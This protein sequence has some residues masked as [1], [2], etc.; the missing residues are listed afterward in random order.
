MTIQSDG[1]IGI[2]TTSP[3]VGGVM[4]IYSDTQAQARL[5]L[6]GREFY[7]G[8]TS[9]ANGIAMLVGVNR[10]DNKQLWIG[11]SEKLA[12]NTTN[13]V[14]RFN[15]G[16]NGET[17]I[18]SYATNGLTP[19]KLGLNGSIFIKGDGNVGIGVTEPQNKL[20]I[21]SGVVGIP[22]VQFTQTTA[23]DNANYALS[24]SGYTNLGGFRVNGADGG[25]S[26]YQTLANTDMTF[27]QNAG[28]TTAGKII[29]TTFGA[30]GDIVF[31]TSSAERMRIKNNGATTIGNTIN[32]TSAN[33][34]NIGNTSTAPQFPITLSST[35]TQNVSI[36]PSYAIAGTGAYT[37]GSVSTINPAIMLGILG[38]SAFNTGFYIYSDKRI[39]KDVKTIENSL[40][41]IEKINPVSFKYIDYVERGT[42]NN[43]GVIAQEIEKII[44]E[45]INSH[46]DFIP[47]IYKNVDSYDKDLL[48][49]YINTDDLDIGDKIKIFDIKNKE[50]LKTIVDKNDDYITIDEEIKDY[51]DESAIFLYG[52][53]IADVK[54]VNYE[55]LFTIN[56]KATQELYQRLRILEEVVRRLIPI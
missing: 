8:S 53:E 54:N 11:D 5:I 45:V 17:G 18:D 22:L 40:D 9:S 4:T 41:L 48:R 35:L 3:N 1:K 31:N 55:A 44:P 32:I 20:H 38:S 6:T 16:G 56:I 30:N 14:L 23:W 47:N 51:E 43:Y 7:T 50:H 24:V 52:K 10:T 26:I 39:K 29:F 12:V 33:Y 36:S 27:L 28:N 42:I 19:F 46:K 21:S 49:L 34:I 25:G 15:V 13:S 37:T 2:G